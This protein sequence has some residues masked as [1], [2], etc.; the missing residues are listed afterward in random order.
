M[1]VIFPFLVTMIFQMKKIFRKK[2]N[3]QNYALNHNIIKK[4]GEGNVFNPGLRKYIKTPNKLIE[5]Q[6]TILNKFSFI[7]HKE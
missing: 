6:V 1:A 2:A 5:R 3:S 7:G 4:K